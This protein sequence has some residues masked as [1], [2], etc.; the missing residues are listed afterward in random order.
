[1]SDEAEVGESAVRPDQTLRLVSM[2][3]TALNFTR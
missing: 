3:Y 2:N 1:M